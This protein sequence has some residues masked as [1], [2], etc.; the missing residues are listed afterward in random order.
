MSWSVSAVGKP[1]AV[2]AALVASFEQAKRN[3]ANMPHEQA[4]V[5][6]AEAA[7]NAE[8]DFLATINN[9]GPVAVKVEASGHAYYTDVNEPVGDAV[10]TKRSGSSSFSVKVEPLYGFVE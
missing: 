9:P 6:A 1:A 2:K 4:G 5:N 10:K 7:V 3:T 8:L